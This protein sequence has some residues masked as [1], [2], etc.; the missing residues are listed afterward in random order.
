MPASAALKLEGAEALAEALEDGRFDQPSTLR[1]PSGDVP[2][3]ALGV[4]GTELDDAVNTAADGDEEPAEAVEEALAA[5]AE[6]LSVEASVAD[7]LTAAAG[8]VPAET[9][10]DA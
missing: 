8:A 9:I 4:P 10:A 5:D 2:T 6:E 7:A 3:K 1:V